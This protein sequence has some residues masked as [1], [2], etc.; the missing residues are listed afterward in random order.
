MRHLPYIVAFT[1]LL[2]CNNAGTPKNDKPSTPILN[3]SFVNSYPH[4]TSAFTEGLL[5]HNGKLFESTGAAQEIPQT[6][7][8]FG[9]VD[10]KTGKIDVKVE[11]DR[12]KYF[13]EGIVFLNGNVYQ[14][15][16]QTK[17]GFVYDA[18]TF[19][20]IKEFPLPT[21]EG[22][23]MTTDGSSLIMSDGTDKLTYLDPSSLLVTKTLLVTENGNATFNIN[24]LEYIKGFIYANIWQ[25]NTMVKIDPANG[26]VVAKLDLSALAYQA[27]SIYRGSLEMNGIAYDSTTNHLF[28]TGKMWP[29]IFEIELAK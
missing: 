15:T 1:L 24:E 16:Y 20:K 2:G 7:S 4:D 25:T 10:L 29:K 12:N 18:V 22:W 13:G 28:V 26:A 9:I 8:L 27:Q 3:F 6:R 23:G 14:L 5:F 21:A 19:K 17:V 11:I